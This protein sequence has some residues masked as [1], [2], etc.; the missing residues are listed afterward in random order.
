MSGKERRGEEKCSGVEAEVQGNERLRSA[1]E[2][3]S[4]NGINNVR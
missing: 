1:S 3:H 4:E 2:Q